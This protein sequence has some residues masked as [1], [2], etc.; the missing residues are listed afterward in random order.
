[1]TQRKTTSLTEVCLNVGSGYI[2]SLIVWINIIAPIWDIEVKR[3]DNL[4]ITGIFTAMSVVR[5]Y[6]WR[7][8]FNNKG[9]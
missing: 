7:R 8:L 4:I 1:M 2:L 5:G 3:N 6:F 9:G